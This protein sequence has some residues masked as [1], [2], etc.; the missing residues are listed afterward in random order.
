MNKKI[1]FSI[2]ALALGSM[3]LTSCN[4]DDP[5]KPNEGVKDEIT[6][7]I[8]DEEDHTGL[9]LKTFRALHDE[10]NDGSNRTTTRTQLSTNNS[11]VWIEKD[12]INLFGS[13][14]QYGIL[15][16]ADN[17]KASGN[18]SAWVTPT[19]EYFA[20]SP[21]NKKATISDNTVSGLVVHARQTPVKG[22]FDPSSVIM[23]AYTTGNN[24]VFKHVCSFIKIVVAD[25][26][27]MK[28]LMRISVETKQKDDKTKPGRPIAGT[29]DA[30]I[31]RDANNAIATVSNITNGSNKIVL[32]AP[33]GESIQ[34]GTYYVAILPGD[35]DCIEV[36]FETVSK[37]LMRRNN[38]TMQ[39]ERA[40]IKNFGTFPGDSWTWT[41]DKKQE[42]IYSGNYKTS[43]SYVDQSG[44]TGSKRIFFSAGNL[45]AVMSGVPSN[46]IKEWRLAEHQ[47]DYAGV[48]TD[49]G[50]SS[51]GNYKVAKGGTGTYAY[52]EDDVVD[53]FAW[54]AN[55]KIDGTPFSTDALFKYGIT[56]VTYGSG[57]VSNYFE[58]ANVTPYGAANSCADWGGAYKASSGSSRDWYVLESNEWTNIL[59]GRSNVQDA[60][61]C[62]VVT[63]NGDDVLGFWIFPT[64]SKKWTTWP[65]KQS[66][67]TKCSYDDYLEWIAK[68][69]MFFPIHGY[70]YTSGST[71]QHMSKG[72]GYYWASNAKRNGN[73]SAANA[74]YWDP[75]RLEYS[76]GLK[77][78]TGSPNQHYFVRL[79]TEST[80]TAE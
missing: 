37:S 2:L 72:N 42:V 79:Y 30:T 50:A 5:I 48:G 70:F 67:G 52:A 25:N 55:K 7:D 28:H 36:R 6:G 34:P 21:Y 45:Q 15:D 8:T 31:P 66:S 32:D 17:G 69:C 14:K 78:G 29:F 12:T 77:F 24:L 59:T 26:D 53:M 22:G 27:Q 46:P 63:E 57:K 18:F 47:Y 33:V 16:P 73:S 74:I 38:S 58:N 9:V 76:G 10:T 23:T 75:Y 49:E 61:T 68:G 71:V 11:V 40:H 44:T 13:A 39:F 65:P 54:V 3:C 4:D 56:N 62:T 41:E 19:T 20:V 64:D 1:A 60:F 51:T 80:I 35:I 43:A